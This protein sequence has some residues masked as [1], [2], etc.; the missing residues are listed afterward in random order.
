[1]KGIDRGFLKRCGL[2]KVERIRHG[3]TQD[4]HGLLDK[5]KGRESGREDG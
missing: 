2:K 5:G 4:L 1:M 3:L